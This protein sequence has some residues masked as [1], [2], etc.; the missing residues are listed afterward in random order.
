[1]IKKLTQWITK[2]LEPGR[3]PKKCARGK[4]YFKI[5]TPTLS[6]RAI[7]FSEKPCQCGV[8]S[9]TRALFN[10]QSA[11]LEKK[12]TKLTNKKITKEIL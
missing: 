4:H 3:Y 7:L 5:H 2:L 6:R 9:N 12:L 10:E 11:A 1:M 8:H